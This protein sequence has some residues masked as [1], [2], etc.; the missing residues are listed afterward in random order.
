MRPLGNRTFKPDDSGPE[1]GEKLACELA[2]LGVLLG[3]P[4]E[5]D[6]GGET[7][8]RLVD[9]VVTEEEIGSREEVDVE[10]AE[11]VLLG[12]V[13]DDGS[14]EELELVVLVENDRVDLELVGVEQSPQPHLIA[15]CRISLYPGSSILS[16]AS[17]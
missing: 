12:I 9:E 11:D 7:T 10:T 6:V 1:V 17:V 4:V 2:G 5:D 8:L 16:A 14:T 3:V 13:T 15:P